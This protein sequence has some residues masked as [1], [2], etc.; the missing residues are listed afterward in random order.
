MRINTTSIVLLFGFV[1]TFL[2]FL[3]SQAVIY[4]TMTN[5]ETETENV[6][7][8]ETYEDDAISLYNNFVT[9]FR[10]VFG[11]LAI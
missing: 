6:G 3:G 11:V 9:Y 8:Q 10:A 1:I 7:M 5:M 4:Y 2:I